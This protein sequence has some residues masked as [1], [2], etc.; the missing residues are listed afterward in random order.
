MN[1]SEKKQAFMMIFV[2]V[3]VVVILLIVRAVTKDDEELPADEDTQINVNQLIE[4]DSFSTGKKIGDLEIS[5]IKI[6]AKE[7]KHYLTATVKNLSESKG[8]EETIKIILLDEAGEQ[9][10]TISAFV[11]TIEAGGEI[12]LNS[13]VISDFS[14]AVDFKVEK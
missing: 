2:M 11:G 4:A 3:V 12:T 6:T 14:N 10:T 8:G 7:D 9:L 5:D 13:R 1:K